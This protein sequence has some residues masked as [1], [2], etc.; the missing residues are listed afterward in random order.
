[1][2]N[3][4]NSSKNSAQNE[5]NSQ[6]STADIQ[7]SAVD[8]PKF[9][10]N[11]TNNTKNSRN[12]QKNPQNS[13]TNSQQIQ[14]SSEQNSTQNSSPNTPNLKQIQAQKTA[15]K[16]TL[17]AS[18]GGIL[19]FYDFILYVFFAVAI[20]PQIFFPPQS[21]FWASVGGWVSFGVAYLA[22]PFGAIVFGH[23]GDKFG[24]K[25]IF[26]IS[27]LLMI[28]P[29]FVLALLPVYEHIGIAAT[30]L[31]FGIRIVQGLAVGADVSGV[32][33]F[34]SEFV[35]EKNKPLALGFISASTTFGLLLA[36]LVALLIN[37]VFSHEQVLEFAWR[38]PFV[39]GGIFGIF[40]CFLRKKL[41]ETPVFEELQKRRQILKFPLLQALK[42]HKMPML[43]CFLMSIVLSAGVATLTIIPQNF[44][45]LLGFNDT[46]SLLYTNLA[47]V[48][49]IIG[50]LVQGALAR[51]FG[52][53]KI[54]VIFSCLF[55]AFGFGVGLYDSNFTAY[56]LLACFSQGIITFAP[57][58]MT[59]VFSADV[60]LSG[61]SFAYNLSY[62]FFVFITPFIVQ[63]LYKQHLGYYMSF[64]ALISLACVGL[65][66][67]LGH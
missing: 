24:R 64:V 31:L 4:K 16:N 27:M 12:F 59:R 56:Y 48:A 35:S 28:L 50:A 34:V 38:L 19:E 29:S 60:R 5:R 14:A 46:Q 41:S 51:F 26:Y 30:L 45:I 7:N 23:F 15:L 49:V 55:A 3:S 63:A 65:M 37:S 21:A 44:G 1:M 52:E 18:L 39:L 53:Y 9:K 47:I 33:V 62:A 13:A 2:K 32:W 66:K 54:C 36:G 10:Q 6:I 40:A 58:F 61:L 20:F 57:V 22:R 25:K 17:Y 8:T 67:K 11:S 42:T 43:V